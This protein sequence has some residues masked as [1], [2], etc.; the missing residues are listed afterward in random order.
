MPSGKDLERVS[1]NWAVQREEK[2]L[3]ELSQIRIK[4]AGEDTGGAC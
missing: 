3:E 4:D 2:T 1:P